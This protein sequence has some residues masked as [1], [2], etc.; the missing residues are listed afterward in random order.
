MRGPVPFCEECGVVGVS[1]TGMHPG[2]DGLVRW[3]IYRC[4]H[5]RT[6]ILLEEAAVME[7]SLQATR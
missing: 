3:T 4:G 6:E 7:P 5:T 1:L 2:D